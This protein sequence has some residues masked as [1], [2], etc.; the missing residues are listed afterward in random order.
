M[1]VEDEG[2][3]S[4]GDDVALL[5]SEEEPAEIEEGSEAEIEEVEEPEE[6]V[7]PKDILPHER[8]T[9][10]DLKNAFPE[11]FKKFPSLRD[12]V[13]REKAYTELFPTVEDARTAID[14]SQ[15]LNVVRESVLDGDGVKFF[16]SV[17]EASPDG[18]LKFSRNIL[19]ALF[20]ISPEAHWAAA[21]PLLE[22]IVKGFGNSKDEKVL[23]AA[24][25]FA[26]F[27]FGEDGKDILAGKKTLVQKVEQKQE[28]PERKKFES[29][30]F[31]AFNNDLSTHVQSGVK[32]LILEK[33]KNGNL[34]L[35]PD[36]VFSDWMKNTLTG[37]IAEEIDAQIA[38]DKAHVQYMNGLWSRARKDG[39]SS[40]WKSR[41]S[42]AYLARARQL[43]SSVRSRLVS[44][45]LGTKVKSSD[46]RLKV[47]EKKRVEGSSSGR[48]TKNNEN[49][50]AKKVDWSRTSDDDFLNDNITYKGEK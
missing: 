29:D 20:K 3:S 11:L 47:V 40:E 8:P 37:K 25:L 22:N 5:E 21:T 2:S 1:P 38:A 14:D 13:F 26:E 48:E 23:E 28:D 49:I 31:K 19:P 27:L 36:E 15:A 32:D 33:D 6:E 39:Y 45:A 34:R 4:I 35:D 42:S 12:V 16:E 41:I 30:R 7:E 50:N 46:K 9:F 24:T 43:V 17:K 18:L 44:E 10:T